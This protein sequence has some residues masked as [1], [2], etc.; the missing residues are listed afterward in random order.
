MTDDEK[1]PPRDKGTG[2][3]FQ[4][5]RD[6]R[7]VAQIEAGF[8]RSGAR[9]YITQS[10]KTETEAK[11]KLRA[12]QNKAAKEGIPA[13]G[14]GG[15]TVKKWSDTWLPLYQQRVRPS[16]FTD[17]RGVVRRYI[18]P[19]IG[20]RK[21]DRLTPADVRSVHKACR[22]AGYEEATALRSHDVLMVMLKAAEL[23]GHAV[24]S[25]V[26][27][28]PRP[29][30]PESGRDAIPLDEAMA[31]LKA[32]GDRPDA[33]RWAAALLQG[34]RQAECLGLTWDCV[35]LDRA[36]MD[37][38]WQLQRLPYDDRALETFRI[39]R[40]Y[41]ARRLVGAAHLVRP[42]SRERVVPL[43]E[44]M[45]EALRW[46]KETAPPNPYGLVWTE[47]EARPVRKGTDRD[48]WFALQDAARVAHVDEHGV[49]RRYTLHEARHTTATLLLELGVDSEVIRA[50]VGHSSVTTTRGYQHV[51][52]EL[53]RRALEGLATTLQFGAQRRTLLPQP[54]GD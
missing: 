2:S 44:P 17:A 22:D 30:L 35:D 5:K 12:M 19:T 50:I 28:T 7:W 1:K 34:M 14:G 40:D 32:A 10:A 48:A 52:Q 38:S 33:T 4:R 46:W 41:T 49:G 36:L 37:V 11:R 26:R 54:E 53:S 24:P 31:L 47:A 8:T 23:E 20:T 21:L 13:A 43:V 3:V 15:M 51:S 16:R 9:R 6:G 18:V 39:P 25:N 45:V 29:R 27:L 42:K